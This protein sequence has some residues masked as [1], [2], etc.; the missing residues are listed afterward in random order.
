[1]NKIIE[2]VKMAEKGQV[3]ELKNDLAIVKMS[4]TEACAKCGACKKGM[5]EN[6]MLIEAVNECNANIG[7]WVEIDLESKDFLKAMGIMYGIPLICLMFG[8]VL[9][10][11]CFKSI[12]YNEI[13]GFCLGIIFMSLAYL[14]IKHKE[15]YWK[16]QNFSPIATKKL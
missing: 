14:W 6:E 3:I 7:D 13:I 5:A 9:G 16:E 11:A 4:R 2:G 8:F 10:Y 1:M 12:S 15:S